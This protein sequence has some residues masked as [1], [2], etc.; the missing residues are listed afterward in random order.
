[1]VHDSHT[2]SW[3]YAYEMELYREEYLSAI[4]T[5][6]DS[7]CLLFGE[8]LKSFEETFS[9]YIGTAYS[10]GCDNAT[11]AIF[12]SLKSLG[13]GSGHTVI[14]VPNTAIPTVSA[15][16][17]S[18]ARP[19]FVDVGKNA[20]MDPALIEDAIHPSTKAIL[21]VHLYGYPCDMHVINKIASKHQLSVL[22]DCSQA[23][24]SKIGDKSVGSFGDLSCFSFYPTKPLGGFGDA[25]MICTDNQALNQKLRRLRFYG[26]DSDY[27]AQFDGYNS[28][29]DEIH[30]AILNKKIS[31]LDLSINHRQKILDIYIA[32]LSS[33]FLTPLPPPEDSSTSKYLIPF[34]FEGDR[35]KFAARLYEHGIGTNISYKTPIHLMPAYK[36]L[37]Y[38]EGDFPNAEFFSKQN[39]SFP[40]FNDMP[41]SLAYKIA[42]RINTVLDLYF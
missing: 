27:I 15:I 6:F 25:G 1:M 26:I 38:R 24:G 42:E 16:R 19:I 8:Q 21:P 35:D 2:P 23:H 20:L 31:R 13:I 34:L 37:N 29:M 11:N 18:G 32:T 3:T 12:L 5:V 10:I 7:G 28:R 4:N 33:P 22:E 40:I 9:K 41:E 17:Q 39:I 14:T 36:D 30:A